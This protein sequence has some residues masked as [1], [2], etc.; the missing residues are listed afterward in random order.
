MPGT[1]HVPNFSSSLPPKSPW[2]PCFMGLTCTQVP[3]AR[4]KQ[5]AKVQSNFRTVGEG[6]LNPQH[7][8]VPCMG[9]FTWVRLKCAGRGLWDIRESSRQSCL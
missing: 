2:A 8:N 5:R 1:A 4:S 3:K 7:G 9:L 6:L